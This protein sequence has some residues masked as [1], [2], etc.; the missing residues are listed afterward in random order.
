MARGDF[1]LIDRLW[2]TIERERT[3]GKQKSQEEAR[4]SDSSWLEVAP[5]SLQASPP[6][7]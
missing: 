4:E 6:T 3:A 5:E 1:I 2:R 7:G